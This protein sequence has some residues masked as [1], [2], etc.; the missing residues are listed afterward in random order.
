MKLEQDHAQA[1]ASSLRGQLLRWLMLPLLLVEVAGSLFA[2][3][4]AYDFASR[5]YDVG[6]LDTARS[7][8]QQVKIDRG[9]ATVSLPAAAREIL[10][11]DP[12]DRVFYRVIAG[13]GRTV[14][15]RADVPVP[16]LA[17]TVEDAPGYYDGT[18]GD[19]PVRLVAYAL[20]EGE[21][22]PVATVMVAETLTKRK[23]LARELLLA[24]LAPQVLLLV[25]VAALIWFGVGRGLKPLARVAEA[26]AH[27]GWGDLSGV[28]DRGTP[29]EV[30][31]LTH[32]I[33]DLMARVAQAAS[34]QQRFI[35]DAAH[36]L[37]TP[38]AG[39]SAQVERA[40]RT[41]DL[42]AMQPALAQ[43][44]IS[45]RRATRLVN[46]LLVLARAE[47]EGAPAR[48]FRRF[49]LA[50][51]V[52]QTCAEWVPEALAR[53]VDLGYAG[54]E[55]PVMIEGDEVLLA[56]LLGNL[57]DNAL[58][59]GG[60]GGTVTVRLTGD[61]PVELQVED[62]GPGVPASERDSVFERFHRVAGTPTGGCG[63]GLAIVREIALAHAAT[64]SV[65]EA[66][67]HG[68]AK[69]RVRFEAPAVR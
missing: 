57:I 67:P 2:Y 53:N 20:F 4:V 3:A 55:G 35:A 28:S 38:L 48:S 17:P 49:D 13:D 23:R 18:V 61:P 21:D 40:L 30:Q 12:V 31:P 27:R 52:Q 63:L 15:G 60:P 69:F 1:A 47:P 64:V 10:E 44:Q 9:T 24:V 62:D 32:A 50:R 39:L 22:T 5:A 25:V 37:R 66:G 26:I 8:A 46:Q 29:A 7:L 59:Y 33:N 14:A 68:G 36:Q 45:A 34:A 58:R 54:E 41:R 56:E 19:A 65:G 11:S 51:V 6:L 43:L 42:D 16:N